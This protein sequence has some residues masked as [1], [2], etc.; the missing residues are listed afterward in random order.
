[1][2]SLYQK[3]YGLA[4]DLSRKALVGRE[5]LLG[6]DHPDYFRSIYLHARLHH[7][8]KEYSQAEPLYQKACS[9][10]ERVIGAEHAGMKQACADYEQLR[11]QM[12]EAEI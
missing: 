3:R 9:G 8:K 12:K 10:L 2:G 4:L 5:E 7:L 11:E 6:K 1:M